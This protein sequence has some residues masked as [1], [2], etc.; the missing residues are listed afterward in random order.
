MIRILECDGIYHWEILDGEGYVFSHSAYHT[1]RE[2]CE[3]EAR[4]RLEWFREEGWI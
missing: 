2:A 4:E 1:S 3:A